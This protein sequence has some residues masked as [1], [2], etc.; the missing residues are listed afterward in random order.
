MGHLPRYVFRSC[1]VD[2]TRATL[3]TA[4]EANC[5]PAG[6]S[7]AGQWK[8]SRSI[9]RTEEARG[10]NPLTSTPHTSSSE[11]RRSH[12]GG[13]LVVAGGAWGHAGATPGPLGQVNDGA[14]RRRLG[15]AVERVQAVTQGTVGLRVQVAV[16]VR[17]KLTE[18]CPGAS[19]DLLGVGP[20]RDRQ[21]DGSV[22]RSWMRSRSRPAAR[23]A[24]RHTR[25]RNAVTRS[26]PPA[27]R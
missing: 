2:Q 10:S 3:S 20:G 13:A 22:R 4:R 21:G 12:I 18:A 9:P 25:A 17:V 16:T 23:V 26:G 8:N 6:Q 14:C 24:G 5:N 7:I 1:S 11:R 15:A 19:R 27:A